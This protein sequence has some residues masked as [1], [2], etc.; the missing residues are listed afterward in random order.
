MAEWYI[1][2]GDGETGPFDSSQLRAKAVF[3]EIDGDTLLR[4]KGRTSWHKA[5]SIQGLEFSDLSVPTP[6]PS[7]PVAVPPKP[8]VRTEKK[9]T[10]AIAEVPVNPPDLSSTKKC[11]FCAETILSE[12]I[13]C[14]HCGEFLDGSR[15]TALPQD[16]KW[17]DLDTIAARQKTLIYWIIA[18]VPLLGLQF[19]TVYNA[20]LVSIAVGS[21]A[22]VIH[23]IVSIR[24]GLVVYRHSGAGVLVSIFSIVPFLGLL[25]LFVLSSKATKLLIAHGIEVGLMGAKPA[26]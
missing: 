8:I 9:T 7:P 6:A 17:P 3:G 25:I 2:N 14:K 10:Q 26:K 20:P 5:S 18:Q 23:L 15:R 11:P 1:K 22:I 4:P 12:A 24:L 21:V 16:D 19:G 13:K